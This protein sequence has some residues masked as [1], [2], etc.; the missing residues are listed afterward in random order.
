M[1]KCVNEKKKRRG[2]GRN[3]SL[4]RKFGC[5][6]TIQLIEGRLPHKTYTSHINQRPFGFM[7]KIPIQ[8]MID[9]FK[10]SLHL[11]PS[12]CLC[13]TSLLFCHFPPYDGA[14]FFWEHLLDNNIKTTIMLFVTRIWKSFQ[15]MCN[16]IIENKP[17][18]FAAN[19]STWHPSNSNYLKL[20]VFVSFD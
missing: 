16:I 4:Q 2:K 14:A 15:C 7:N 17:S 11:G 10:Q 18:F 9:Y 13:K 5:K 12:I 20:I 19:Y 6:R 1:P 3:S 8:R